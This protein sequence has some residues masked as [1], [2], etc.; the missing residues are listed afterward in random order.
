MEWY[1]KQT[2]LPGQKFF[3]VPLCSKQI[4]YFLAMNRTQF[5]A[6]TDKPKTAWT[7]AQPRRMISIY[8]MHRRSSGPNA[9]PTQ[10]LSIVKTKRLMKAVW[11]SNSCS[12][13]ESYGTHDYIMSQNVELPNLTRNGLH[14]YRLSLNGLFNHRSIRPTIPSLCSNR[15]PQYQTWIW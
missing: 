5:S 10:T 4:W 11:R 9:Q 7:V 13:W 15:I 2:E 14:N 6:V 3:P 8:I 1:C 12:R